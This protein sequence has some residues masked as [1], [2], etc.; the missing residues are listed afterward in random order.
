MQFYLGEVLYNRGLERGG[1]DRAA[2]APSQLNPDNADAHYL[3]AFVLGDMGRH[4]EARGASK[5]AIEL[6][7][8]LARAQ[9]NLS[10]E[11]L[12]ADRRSQPFLVREALEMEV[13]EGRSWRTSTSVS[14]SGRRATTSRRCA[15]TA[16]RWSGAKITG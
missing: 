15:N 6:N 7:P 12:S 8:T 4:H 3:M 11:R 16:W 14:R 5:R 1:P 10:I 9:A 2:S 13:V